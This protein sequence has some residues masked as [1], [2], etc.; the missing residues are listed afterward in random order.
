MDSANGGATAP[1]LFTEEKIGKFR[2]V[3]ICGTA[4]SYKA[5]P[6]EDLD[7]EIWAFS[8]C[9]AMPGFKRADR[10]YELHPKGWWERQDIRDRLNNFG[11]PVYMQDAYPEIPKSVKY[12][13]E[14][15]K[16]LGYQSYFTSSIAYMLAHAVLEKVDHVALFGI[17]MDAEEEYADQRPAC[18][19]WLGVMQGLGMDT[20]LAPGGALFLQ[21]FQY[22]YEEYNPMIGW[23]KDEMQAL[24]NA[25]TDWENKRNSAELARM[26]QIGAIK[27]LDKI[28]R[29]VQR[30]EF[31]TWIKTGKHPS[32]GE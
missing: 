28:S 18:E 9:I 19:Y 16:A 29:A 1:L 13:L 21:K 14:E 5:T 8:S 24:Q 32:K 31:E 25:A 12:P 15:V 30:G 10:I 6:F 4:D 7:F 23:L 11:G 27:E 22:G 2:K 3:A 26:Q 20:Y 17:H